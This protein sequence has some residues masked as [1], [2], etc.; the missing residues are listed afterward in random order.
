VLVDQRG[1]RARHQL[2]R[3][4]A[5]S[6]SERVARVTKVVEAEIPDSGRLQRAV[7]RRVEGG[8]S[9]RPTGHSG[10]HGVVAAGR[11]PV[12]QVLFEVRDDD[13]RNRDLPQVCVGI[14]WTKYQRAVGELLVLLDNRDGA[15]EQV[16]VPLPERTGLADSESAEGRQEQHRPIAGFDASARAKT[17]SIVAT[18][19]SAG[20]STEAPLM[21]HGFRAIKLFSTAV[22]QIAWRS[23]LHLAIVEGPGR[24]F[25][26]ISA[27]QVLI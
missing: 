18:G 24:S 26:I 20:R 25:L 23:R 6:R 12:P 16:K 9:E 4:G 21:T 17:C 8:L 3:A 10:K 19:R 11:A 1:P 14:G 13:F 7:P 22:S 15:V 27:R 5:G 2:L